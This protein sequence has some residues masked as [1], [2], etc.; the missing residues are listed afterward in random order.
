MQSGLAKFVALAALLLAGMT[1][2]A[3]AGGWG[4]DAPGPVVYGWAGCG[5][6]GQPVVPAPVPYHWSGCGGCRLPSAAAVF[7][8]PVAP[9]PIVVSVPAGCCYRGLYR[10]AVPSPLYVVNRGPAFTGPGLTVPYGV[11]APGPAYVPAVSYP[12]ISG[13]DYRGRR[14]YGY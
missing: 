8:E 3:S 2:A 7:T 13:H 9:A 6:C 5:G 10:A 11:Y 12:Y 1:S 4:W 14:I